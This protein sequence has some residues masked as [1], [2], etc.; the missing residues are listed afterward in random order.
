MNRN[1]EHGE[2]RGVVA[3]RSTGSLGAE[4]TS[5]RSATSRLIGTTSWRIE[6]WLKSSAGVW[7]GSS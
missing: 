1:G 7:R 4:A 3:G 5:V 2:Q 6:K